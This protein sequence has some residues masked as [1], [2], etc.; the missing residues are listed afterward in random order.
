MQFIKCHI[1]SLMV[2]LLYGSDFKKVRDKQRSLLAS[3]ASKRPEASVFRLTDEDFLGEASGSSTL[4]ELVSGLGLFGG[5][6]VVVLDGVLASEEDAKEKILSLV[7]A[8]AETPHIFIF[9]ENKILA[10]EKKVFEKA[11]AK[12]QE[13][14]TIKGGEK[15]PFNAFALSDAL[16]EKNKKKLWTLYRQAMME[17]VEPEQIAGTLFWQLKTLMLVG[18]RGG[19]VGMKP[20]VLSK[21]RKNLSKWERTELRRAS[22]SLLRAY[23]EPR[24]SGVEMEVELEKFILDL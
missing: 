6:Y 2:Y 21:A 3:L 22:S 18:E 13:L 24:L 23:H 5:S 9:V 16:G 12:I 14:N 19:E 17:S 1:L 11:E 4:E 7:P 8:M 15:K 20:F 10:K